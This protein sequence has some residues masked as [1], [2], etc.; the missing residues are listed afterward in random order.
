MVFFLK[1]NLTW[2]LKPVYYSV[3]PEASAIIPADQRHG[4]YRQ[5]SRLSAYPHRC[6]PGRRAPADQSTGTLCNA[7]TGQLRSQ[8]RADRQALG[9]VRNRRPQGDRLL[10]GGKAC[11]I[12][13]LTSLQ[14]GGWPTS[15]T[16]IADPD[17][18][19]PA[20]A[21]AIDVTD[22]RHA[23]LSWRV[24]SR[25]PDVPLVSRA[26]L[27]SGWAPKLSGRD[28]RDIQCKYQF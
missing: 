18:I 9:T 11:R 4:F 13:E 17:S 14:P 22:Q 20:L 5:A 7:C 26:C 3:A 10:S 23:D 8:C 24:V 15:A 6:L 25:C 16:L 21:A 27:Y 19:T 2:Q 12:V 1:K 28:K